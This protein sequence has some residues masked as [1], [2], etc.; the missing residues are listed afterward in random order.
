MVK[1]N[2]ERQQK[3]RKCWRRGIFFLV[4]CWQLSCLFPSSV[5]PLGTCHLYSQCSRIGQCQCTPPPLPS[6]RSSCLPKTC[7]LPYS[8]MLWVLQERPSLLAWG[9]W[10]WPMLPGTWQEAHLAVGS[11][12][13]Y[14][15]TYGQMNKLS[16]LNLLLM[17][18]YFDLH[19]PDF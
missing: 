7:V 19:L 2:G 18:W 6:S 13:G 8:S 17:R 16:I 12:L 3:S 15:L 10:Q 4:T 11:L 5:T 1:P 14:S 9:G